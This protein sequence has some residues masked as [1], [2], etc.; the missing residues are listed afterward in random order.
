M[1]IMMPT[2]KAIQAIWVAVPAMPEKP[3]TPAIIAIMRNI[4]AQLIMFLLLVFLIFI[5]KNLG[6]NYSEV[7]LHEVASNT[8]SVI[9][10]HFK[11]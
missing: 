2:T 7:Y 10:I 6:I 1:A 11:S 8:C 5:P 9:G 3:R 4:T